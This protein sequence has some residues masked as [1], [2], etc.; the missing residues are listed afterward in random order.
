MNYP[1]AKSAP[2]ISALL[3]AVIALCLALWSAAPLG[4]ASPSVS[5]F[6]SGFQV[7][8]S[9][10]DSSGEL[11]LQRFSSTRR[12]DAKSA[13]DYA[14]LAED[15]FLNA[16]YHKAVALLSHAV[17]LAPSVSHYRQ[18]L[19]EAYQRQAESSSFPAPLV[20]R[21]RQH[22]QAALRLDPSNVDALAALVEM[23][24]LPAGAC[25]GDLAQA[26]RLLDSI[27]RLDPSRAAQE[28]LALESAL[29]DSH[30]IENRLRCGPVT[31]AHLL[32]RESAERVRPAEVAIDAG[33]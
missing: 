22:L 32:G 10:P 7:A 30:S 27:E 11:L 17:R 25:Y 24:S 26:G 8:N 20:Y 6:L 21:A 23:A 5:M 16:D 33:F 3:P 15:A 19:G 4:A 12:N 18:R 14:R 9:L 28:R 13:A 29:S 2:W 31:V 1:R